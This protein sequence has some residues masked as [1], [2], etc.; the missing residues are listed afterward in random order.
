MYIIVDE[1]NKI[2]K[3]S[4]SNEN[5]GMISIDTFPED[6]LFSPSKYLYVDNAFI[7]NPD[8]IEPV[9]EELPE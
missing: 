5:E 4:L 3:A 9:K 7:D 6:L 1:T 2:I 8:Y